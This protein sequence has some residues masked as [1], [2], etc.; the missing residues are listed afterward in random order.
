M[1]VYVILEY[2]NDCKFNGKLPSLEGLFDFK[3]SWRD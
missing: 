2:F 3:S 1:S